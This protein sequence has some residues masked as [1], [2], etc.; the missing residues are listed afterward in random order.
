MKV[1]ITTESGY[2]MMQRDSETWY[3]EKLKGMSNKRARNTE[4]GEW[5]ENNEERAEQVKESGEGEQKEE[6]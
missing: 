1:A 2:L 6:V 5:N 3:K 4:R